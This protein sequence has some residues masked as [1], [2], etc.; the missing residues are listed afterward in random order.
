MTI[1]EQIEKLQETLDNLSIPSRFAL[2]ATK[3]SQDAL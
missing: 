3:S 1:K 2:Y